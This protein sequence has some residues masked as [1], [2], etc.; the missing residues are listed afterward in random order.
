ME[1]LE[2]IKRVQDGD[3]E[4]YAVLVRKHH[5][6]LL[7]FIHRLVRDR[8][9]AEDIGQEVFL[10]AFKA[11]PRFDP[12]RGTPFRA[13]L[14]ILARNRCVS[15]LRGR[16]RARLTPLEDAP[17]LAQ[18]GPDQDMGMDARLV[19]GEELAALAECLE[20]LGEPFRSTILLSL[21]GEPV[22]EI[23]CRCGVPEATVKTRLF[24]A[25]EKLR[26]L[27]PAALGGVCHEP[28]I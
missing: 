22:A 25:R 14:F 12:S 17:E 2:T 3:T 24:R 15:E 19:A 27:L 1:D 13:W 26:R 23:A 7:A 20:K 9:L 16:L 18:A 28:E 10:D 21:T 8:H 11:L 5:R 4:A 6:D